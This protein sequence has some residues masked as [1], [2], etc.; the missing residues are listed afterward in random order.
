MIKAM[1]TTYRFP[2]GLLA[3]S[4]IAFFVFLALGLSGFPRIFSRGGSMVVLLGAAA[5][6]ALM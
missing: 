1:F 2:L 4:T 6:Y 5:E 3:A